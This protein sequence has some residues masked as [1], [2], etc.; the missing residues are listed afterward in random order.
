MAGEQRRRR[1]RALLADAGV[2]GIDPARLEASFVHESAVRAGTATRSNE[3]LEFLGDAVL[4][5]I[6]ARG[7]YDRFPDAPEGELTLRK[8]ALVNDAALCATAERLGLEPLLVMDSGLAKAPPARRRSLLADAYEA[9][10][11]SIFVEGGLERAVRF[12]ERSHVR[13]VDMDGPPLDDPKTILQEWA[14]R[15]HR[16]L[17]VYAERADGPAHERTYR[18]IVSIEGEALGS[19]TGASKKEAQRAAA[20]AAL[21]VVRARGAGQAP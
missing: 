8:S 14:Q 15:R 16:E 11:A 21:E 2:R 20:A 6:V 19:G 13:E 3:R 17:P 10:V 1:L 9:L 12:V 18:S 5:M 4:G 7:L